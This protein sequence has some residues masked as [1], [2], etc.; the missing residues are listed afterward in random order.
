MKFKLLLGRVGLN[1]TSLS[2][3]WV[4]FLG[5]STEIIHSHFSS[6]YHSIQNLSETKALKIANKVLYAK[7]KCI[8]ESYK[9][10]IREHYDGN[11]G[12]ADFGQ[13]QKVADVSFCEHLLGLHC[14]WFLERTGG[15]GVQS[16]KPCIWEG[17]G[18][19]RDT[20]A[21]Q[22][23]LNEQKIILL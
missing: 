23:Y 12:S 14:P 17:R 2:F 21:P 10:A 6:L 15:G 18:L 13:A 9:A 3:M 22:E 5:V 19:L 1:L 16:L 8:L 20:E 4:K 7:D 11:I